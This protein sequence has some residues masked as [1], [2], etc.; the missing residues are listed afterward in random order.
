[1]KSYIVAAAILIFTF[2]GLASS[3]TPG[4][5]DCYDAK[6]V[7]SWVELE[8][9]MLQGNSFLEKAIYRSG[10]R[11]ALGVVHGFTE[12]ELLDPSRVSRILSIIRGICGLRVGVSHIRAG[13]P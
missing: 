4:V 13:G 2:A 10:D 12:D 3:D 5:A 7:R 6:L 9:S 8:P 11:I 1:M